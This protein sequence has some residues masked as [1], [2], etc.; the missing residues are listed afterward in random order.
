MKKN[1][2]K[3]W[4]LG[5]AACAVMLLLIAFA[6]L[7]KSADVGLACAFGAVFGV[8]SRSGPRRP[9]PAASA[10]GGTHSVRCTA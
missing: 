4:Y 1:R 7:P 3:L 5:Y 8:S 9:P 6:G 2:T 10:P